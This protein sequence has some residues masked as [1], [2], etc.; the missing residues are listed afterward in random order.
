MLSVM[1]WKSLIQDLRDRGKTYQ[2][3][4]TVAGMS[5]GAVH[6]LHHGRKSTVV[7]ETGLLLADLHKRATKRRY[8]RGRGPEESTESPAAPTQKGKT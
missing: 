2:E 4:A 1:N 8:V 7:Y 6:D 3:I 5:R